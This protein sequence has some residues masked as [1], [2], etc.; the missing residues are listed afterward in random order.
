MDRRRPEA[1]TLGILSFFYAVGLAGHFWAPTRPWLLLLTPWFL[2]AAGGAAAGVSLAGPS[3][4]P[5]LVWG[6]PVLAVTFGLEVLG[7]A[8]GLVFGPYHYSEVLGSLWAGV[9]PVIGFNWVLVVLGVWSAAALAFPRWSPWGRALAV[10]LGCVAFDLLLEPV[11]IGL[12]YWVWHSPSVPLQNYLAWGLIAAA[13]AGAAEGVKG[14]RPSALMA[15][16]AALQAA[17]FAALI[18][19]GLGG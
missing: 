8:T 6:L 12:G 14:L 4:K 11:A 13:A 1:L 3:W 15:G 19:G 10:G 18:L 16:Y 5:A 7:V 17:F 2:A 9:P